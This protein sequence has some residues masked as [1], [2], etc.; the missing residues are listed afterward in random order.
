MLPRPAAGVWKPHAVV[1]FTSGPKLIN[2][3]AWER[4]FA[5]GLLTGRGGAYSWRLCYV[6]ANRDSRLKLYN[7][8]GYILIAV[9]LWR[10][11]WC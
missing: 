1:P 2:E 8:G 7:P 3:P 4:P 6:D 5:S 10:Y 9:I 11:S